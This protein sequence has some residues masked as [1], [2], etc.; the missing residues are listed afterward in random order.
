MKIRKAELTD[1]F[2]ITNILMDEMYN[3]TGIP[4]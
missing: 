3:E 1:I 4:K 2:E